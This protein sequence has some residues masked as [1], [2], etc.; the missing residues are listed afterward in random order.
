MDECARGLCPVTSDCK[1]SA[2]SYECTC[3]LGYTH[4]QNGT[5]QLCINI[6]EC[7]YEQMNNCAQSCHD[8][9]GSFVCSCKNGYTTDDG[10]VTC[11]SLTVKVNLEEMNI[12]DLAQLGAKLTMQQKALYTESSQKMNKL[13]DSINIEELSPTEAKNVTKQLSE[14]TLEPRD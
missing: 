9:V 2:G 7:D 5:R 12:T 8:T 13:V 10:G 4:E 3:H 14:V 6:D 1:D 11:N